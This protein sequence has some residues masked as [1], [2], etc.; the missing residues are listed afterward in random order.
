[1]PAA[2]VMP[3]PR[4]IADLRLQGIERFASLFESQIRSQHFAVAVNDLVMDVHRD[5]AAMIERTRDEAAHFPLPDAQWAA[6]QMQLNQAITRCRNLET[7]LPLLLERRRSRWERNREDLKRI[8]F[9]FDEATQRLAGSVIEKDLLERQ[10]SVLEQIILSHEKVTQWKS[11]VRE[12]LSGFHAIFPFQYFFIAF[13]EEHALSLNLYY[14][15]RPSEAAKETAR[16]RLARRMIRQLNLP[17][18]APLDIE[19]FEIH[20]ETAIDAGADVDLITVEV[21]EIERVN[22]AGLLGIAYVGSEQPPA[23][24]AS[25]I[26]SILAVMVMVVGSSKALSRTLGELEYYSVHDPLTGLHNRRYFNEMLEY[27]RGRSERHGH[28]FSL[29]MLDLDDFKDV[30]DTYGHPCG[31]SVLQRVAEISRS[32]L[33]KGDLAARLGGDEFVILLTETG[34]EGSLVVAEKLRGS[35]RETTFDDPNGRQ[36]HITGSIG[37][38]TYPADAQTVTDLMAGVDLGLYRAKELGKDGVGTMESVHDRLHS[39]RATRDYAEKLRDALRENRIVPYFQPI[40]DSAGNL[41]A[42]ETLARLVEP[43]GETVAAGAFIETI[44]K[45][46][47]GRELDR[48]VIHRALHSLRRRIDEGGQPVRLFINL[49]SQEIQGRGVLGYAEE[50][51]AELA[52]PPGIVVFEILERDAIGDMT[53]M[54]TFLSTLRNKGFLFALDD[55]G[56]GYNS[57]H[58]LRELSF[59]FVK[60]DGA[61][62][63]NI[64]NSKVDLSLVRNLSRLC[65]D[66]GIRTVGEF[67]ESAELWQSLKNL[68]IDFAQGFHLGMPTPRMP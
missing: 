51:C 46:G 38:V 12:I 40:F 56:S 57:F 16:T 41:F 24:E 7:A 8:L 49:S 29:L 62:V 66:L 18:D 61:F 15:G 50:I 45:Y 58:Y 54:R 35:L 25:V 28:A 37:T 22:L 55:F 53:H 64:L 13:V 60:I 31:D 21:P 43:N 36:F 19:E 27:E 9:R 23:Q 32:V 63:R 6:L 67:V 2:S 33:R 1:M 30:N 34:R 65:Q 44:E 10:S 26:R 68:G 17:E 5:V 59:D 42:Y 20:A 39:S 3:I 52:I 14:I 4:N 11:F 48:A 47:L